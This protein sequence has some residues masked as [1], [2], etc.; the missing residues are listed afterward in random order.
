MKK[1]QDPVEKL[2][3]ILQ[4]VESGVPAK[5]ICRKYGFAENTLYKWKSRYGG[6]PTSEARRLKET[7]DASSATIGCRGVER[8]RD[9]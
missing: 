5:E 7:D 9:Q 2:I 3:A 8:P 6:M 4:E 1:G